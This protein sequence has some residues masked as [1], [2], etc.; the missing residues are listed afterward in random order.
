MDGQ[1]FDNREGRAPGSA[2]GPV[3]PSELGAPVRMGDPLIDAFAVDVPPPAAG[4]SGFSFSRVLRHKWLMLCVF[5]VVAGA[6]I[7]AVWMFV[8]PKY[9]SLAS[10]RVR[11]TISPIIFDVPEKNGTVMYYWQFLS[12]QASIVNGSSVL[13]AVLDREDV[14]A[15][16]WYQTE[17]QT[18]RT[19]L[20]AEP[21]SHLER[22]K[23]ILEAAP[24]RNTELVDVAVT[25]HQGADSKVLVNA[26]VSEYFRYTE[27]HAEEGEQLVYQTLREE[28]KSLQIDIGVLVE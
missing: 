18:L 2:L 22:L 10:L 12:T 28:E 1:H 25:T 24:R 16:Q 9:R 20:G 6:A 19:L 26:V 11:P 13:S 23:S 17:P 5:L 4:H 3:S 15:T 21:P 27:E 7:P 14:R 8:A